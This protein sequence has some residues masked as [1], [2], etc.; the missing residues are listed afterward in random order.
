MR[1]GLVQIA[2]GIVIGL[3]GLALTAATNGKTIFIGAMVVGA[4]QV[5]IGLFN[6]ARAGIAGSR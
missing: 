2:I 6:I 4:L 1:A 3:I 5:V